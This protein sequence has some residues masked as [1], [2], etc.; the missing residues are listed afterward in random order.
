MKEKDQKRTSDK[1]KDKETTET[2][3]KG[4]KLN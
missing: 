1:Q 3:D 4:R 2:Q